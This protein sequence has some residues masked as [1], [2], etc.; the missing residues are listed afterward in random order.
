MASEKLL[1]AARE[2]LED[3]AVERWQYSPEIDAKFMVENSRTINAGE[4][5]IISDADIIGPSAEAILVDTI[6][7]NEGEA[8][9][10]TYKVTL[11]DRKKKT[12]TE[13]QS[14]EQSSS[15]SVGS[16]TE[17]TSNGGDSYFQLDENG[18]VTLKPQYQNLW[19]PGWLASGGIGQ[20]GSGGSGLIT[21]VKGVADLGTPI[22]V[23]NLTET[24]SAKAIESIWEAVL[25]LQ[26]SMPSVSLNNGVSYST[27]AINGTSANFYTKAQ[28][29]TLL[30][31]INAFDY[32]VAASL[33]TASANT[34]YKI[35]LIP[36]AD[37]QT[38]N[39]KDEYIT[40]RGGSEGGYTYSWEQIGSTAI[41]L[42]GYATESWVESWV[43]QQ[44][45]LKTET[46][47]T[48]PAWAKASTKPSYAFSEITNKPTTLSGYG[49]TD[50]LNK[51][52]GGNISGDIY[53]TYEVE[54]VET[55]EIEVYEMWK[56]TSNGEASFDSLEIGGVGI[57]PSNLVTR[58]GAQ[59]IT[60]AKTFSGGITMSGANIEPLT[61]ST[62]SLGYSSKRFSDGNIRNLH[63]TTFDF[64][65]GSSPNTQVGGIYCGGDIMQLQLGSGA[66][67]GYYNFGSSTGVFHN[68]N[69]AV[70]CG[71]SDH[72]WSDVYSN[73]V[74]I[75]GGLVFRNSSGNKT[76]YISAQDGYMFFQAGT[77]IESS[78]K[79]L[80]FNPTLG[81][82]P[83]SSGLALGYNG[84]NYRWSDIYGVNANLT[85]DLALASTSHID[86]GPARIEYDATTG[87]IHI[88]TNQTGNN[89]P[90]I[91][92]YADG[93]SASG[94]IGNGGGGGG[95]G[96]EQITTNEDGTIDF[97]FTGGDI[98]TVDLNHEHP[99]YPKYVQ[100]TQAEYDALTTKESDT[101]YLIPATA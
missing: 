46:D 71:R 67:N 10:P 2:L 73:E 42:T 44:G 30:N 83:E 98:T 81:L 59:T 52:T 66:A 6:T 27:I 41:D 70:P 40:I 60:G 14:P 37:P 74:D 78:Y 21:S 48:V 11:R 61:D 56:I 31:A 1:D 20:G 55:G 45:F 49:I 69:G 85:G 72:R 79:Q 54:D 25:G 38:G 16:I 63:V 7:I 43:N 9:I 8:A 93:F 34:M 101:L 28:V 5:L 88:T 97:H 17:S 51:N 32:V 80:T 84:A 62:C 39:I 100:C 99:Q 64:R 58:S 26:Q 95:F 75:K 77:N 50:A 76:G 13:S 86:I 89:A 47:P 23:E 96:V 94:G 68:G 57:N 92:F 19:I 87:A 3:S 15:K 90:T 22:A 12:W 53:N 65:D 36:S 24:F 35:Y 4:Y 33:P 82:Y 18:N 91:G 29:D